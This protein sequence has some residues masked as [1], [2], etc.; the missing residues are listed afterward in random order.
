MKKI[1]KR[2]LYL[3]KIRP[4]Y[5]IDLIKVLTGIRRCGKSIILRQIADELVSSFGVDKRQ[6][7]YIDFEDFAFDDIDNAKKLYDLLKSKIANGEKYYIFLDEIQHV[8]GFEKVIASFKA[9]ANCSIFITGSNS[10]LLSGELS[11]LLVG[12]AVEFKV[13]PFSFKEAHDYL[14][15]NGRQ[16]G[17]DFLYDYLKFGGLPQRFDFQDE[18]D[19]IKYLKEHYRGICAKD[20]F[21]KNI[22]LDKHKFSAISSYV[23]ANA[24]K[25]FSAER[26]ANFYNSNNA[27][28]GQSIDRK[29]IYNYLDRMEKVFFITWAKRFNITGKEI[30]KSKEKPYAVDLGLRYINTNLVNYEDTYFL[31]NLVYNEL[32]SRGFEVFVGKTY[33]GE[34]DFVAVNNSRKCFIQVAYLHSSPETIK[35]E[36]GAFSP[37]RDASPKYV[38]SLDKIDLSQNG[39][40]HLNIVDFLL[41]KVD[42]HLS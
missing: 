35:R 13:F 20:V 3:K 10:R 23:L 2:E 28:G 1:I 19:V 34:I 16:V 32:L 26:I 22:D 15:L 40:T 39:I 5:D 37:I 14:T 41:G 33:K 24:G 6:I 42:L 11:S 30:L 18:S 27:K 8:D 4:F 29:A 7:I 25:E 12:R 36:F 9:T 31:E 21:K 17:D 38:L